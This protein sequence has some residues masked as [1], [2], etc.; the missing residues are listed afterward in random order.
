MLPN[1]LNH[2]SAPF[3]IPTH[4]LLLCLLLNTS[5]RLQSGIELC[6]IVLWGGYGQ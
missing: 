5:Q 4:V 1:L 3:A 2:P 6:E